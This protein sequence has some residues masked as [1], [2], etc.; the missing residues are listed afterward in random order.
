MEDIISKDI[1]YVKPYF[2]TNIQ[3]AID[4]YRNPDNYAT[5]KADIPKDTLDVVRRF[6]QHIDKRIHKTGK[7]SEQYLSKKLRHLPDDYRIAIKNHLRINYSHNDSVAI[8]LSQWDDV[9]DVANLSKPRITKYSTRKTIWDVIES[10]VP[11]MLDTRMWYVRILYHRK[12]KR[13]YIDIREWQQNQNAIYEPT[14]I[15]YCVPIDDQLKLLS[16]IHKFLTKHSR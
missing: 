6:I 1:P 15:G 5:P 7:L 2:Q 16:V 4:F 11:I 13:K 3:R 12:E 8:L 14:M 9:C 10:S